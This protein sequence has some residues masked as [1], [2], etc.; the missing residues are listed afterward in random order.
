LV[1]PLPSLGGTRLGIT[2]CKVRAGYTIPS[3]NEVLLMVSLQ[4]PREAHD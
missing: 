4:F 1:P 3:L 2:N